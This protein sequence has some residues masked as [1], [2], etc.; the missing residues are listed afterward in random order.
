M[1]SQG[2]LKSISDRA[3]RWYETQ[4]KHELTDDQLGKDLAIDAETGE[5]EIGDDGI[6]CYEKL[7][8]RVPDAKVFRMK[9]GFRTAF[10]MGFAGTY[11]LFGVDPKYLVDDFELVDGVLH[12]RIFKP[13]DAK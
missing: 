7:R 10:R 4:I 2:E 6:A 12:Y 13:D 3:H 8:E 5:Y 9:H 1:K 11:G